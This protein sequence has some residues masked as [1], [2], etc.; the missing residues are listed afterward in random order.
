MHDRDYVSAL[1][2]SAGIVPAVL[3][4][5]NSGLI[6]TNRGTKGKRFSTIQVTLDDILFTRMCLASSQVHG[7][8]TVPLVLLD[9]F[10]YVAHVNRSRP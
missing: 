1:E 5:R 3:T 10:Q 4:P 9:Y 6:P 2:F 7:F 8:L